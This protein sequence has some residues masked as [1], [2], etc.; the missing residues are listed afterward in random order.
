MQTIYEPKGRAK[1][2]GELALNLYRGCSHGCFYCYAPKVLRITREDFLDPQPKPNI[3]EK[4]K[5]TAPQYT[6]LEVFLCFTCDPYQ[7]IDSKLRLTRQALEIFAQNEIKPTILTKGGIRS[8]RDFDILFN[9]DG[10]YGATLTYLDPALSQL[11][12]PTA[13][14]PQERI[15][16]LKQAHESRIYTWVSLEPVIDPE[17][18]LEI[19]RM[20]HEYVNEYRVGKWNHDERAKE[21][22]WKAFTQ[23]AVT[24]LEKY[25]K[26]YYIKEDLRKYL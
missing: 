4:L 10:K 15:E 13:A 7:P 19:I 23:K 22:D 9:C 17:Q 16:A 5:K 12:E 14:P 1:E 21:I 26:K 6:G 20:T 11:E 24:L 18:S 2:Y 3:I 8:T 25:N